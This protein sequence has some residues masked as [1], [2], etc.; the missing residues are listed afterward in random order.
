MPRDEPGRR[1]LDATEPLR[2]MDA[3]PPHPGSARPASIPRDPDK[4]GW[5]LG[6]RE[7]WVLYR[8]LQPGAAAQPGLQELDLLERAIREDGGWEPV[9]DALLGVRQTPWRMESASRRGFRS[10]LGTGEERAKFRSALADAKPKPSGP[11]AVEYWK[12]PPPEVPKTPEQLA[13]EKRT[14]PRPTCG[15]PET[16]KEPTP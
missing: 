1:V 6:T 10:L 8:E 12:P 9:R 7:V 15:K 4:P 11:P 2:P 13:E 14:R 5:P 3:R 16:P